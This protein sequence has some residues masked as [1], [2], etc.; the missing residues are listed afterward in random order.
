VLEREREGASDWTDDRG[1]LHKPMWPGFDYRGVSM[2]LLRGFMTNPKSYGPYTDDGSRWALLQEILETCAARGIRLTIVLPPSHAL[3]MEMLWVSGNWEAFEHWKRRIVSMVEAH[4]E[5]SGARVT[6]WDFTTHA[7]RNAEAL[8]G[9]VDPATGRRAGEQQVMVD[10]LETSHFTRAYGDDMIE[11]IMG[12][13][14]RP[15]SGGA[16]GAAIGVRLTSD[17][18]EAHLERL[19]GDRAWYVRAFSADAR[20]VAALWSRVEGSRGGERE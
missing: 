13:Q 14:A 2:G 18:L 8:P 7:G 10:W 6:I 5:V 15:A 4:E 11:A 20:Q 19:R 17:T 3:D 16:E 12:E 9:P 1:F